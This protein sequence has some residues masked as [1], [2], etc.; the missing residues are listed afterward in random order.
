[1]KVYK[2][3]GPGTLMGTWD[4]HHGS[5]LSR[6]QYVMP[7]LQLDI[8]GPPWRLHGISMELEGASWA[9]QKFWKNSVSTLATTGDP[10]AD[11]SA[12][13]SCLQAPSGVARV[14]TPTVF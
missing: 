2:G 3:R 1:M 12:K 8:R 7:S 9:T 13:G 14:A 10:R 11:V 5:M 6:A 4:L